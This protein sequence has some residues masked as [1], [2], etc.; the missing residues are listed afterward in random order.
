MYISEFFHFSSGVSSFNHFIHELS[1]DSDVSSLEYSSAE[2]SDD[3]Y[4]EYPESPSSQSSRASRANWILVPIH[5]LLGIPFR[6]FQ[7][8]YSGSGVSKPSLAI[9]ANQHPSQSHFPNKVQSLKDQIIHRTTDR[10]RGIIEVVQLFSSLLICV[11][12]S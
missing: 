7:L 3:G 11:V 1:V 2:D 9:S 12:F 6:L 4:E 10:R 8:A 5:L